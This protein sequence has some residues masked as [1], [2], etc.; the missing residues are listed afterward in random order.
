MF[1]DERYIVMYLCSTKYVQCK[2]HKLR[3]EN[4]KNIT[5]VFSAYTKIGRKMGIFSLGRKNNILLV[6][7]KEC[8]STGE[9]NLNLSLS[10]GQAAFTFLPI[11]FLDPHPLGKYKL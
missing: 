8:I 9:K 4:I 11:S 7:K 1:N 10:F 6:K 2:R 3:I 5:R